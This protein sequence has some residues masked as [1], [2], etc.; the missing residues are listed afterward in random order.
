MKAGWGDRTKDIA[1]VVAATLLFSLVEGIFILPSHIAH[2]KALRTKQSDKS[3]LE[4]FSTKVLQWFKIKTYMPML[5]FCINHPFIAPDNSDRLIHDYHR[6]DQR[7]AAVIKTTF[8]PALEADYVAI[9]LEM[10]AGTP[11]AVTD[12]I[13]QDLQKSIVAVNNDYMDS[14]DGDTLITAITRRVGPNTHEGTISAP[15]IEGRYRDWTNT[16][17][18]GRIRENIGV[19]RGRGTSR[20]WMTAVVFFGKPVSIVLKSDN[21]QKLQEGQGCLEDRAKEG[22]RFSGCHR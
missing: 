5:K 4:I 7:Q 12:S 9:N 15:L 8:F 18:A 14:H 2:S 17:V 20:G 11:D 21:L 19:G 1:F 10:P 16:E 3:K 22:R 13:L 6:C